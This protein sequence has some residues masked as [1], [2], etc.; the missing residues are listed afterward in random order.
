M[1]VHEVKSW[2]EYFTPISYGYRFH[3]L[4]RNDRNYKTGDYM[5][6]REF[7]PILNDYTS[8]TMMVQITDITSSTTPCAESENALDPD[9]CI[10]SIKVVEDDAE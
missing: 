2:P 10:L 1:I 6:L 7:D 5:L 8:D 3:E 9:F 4:R